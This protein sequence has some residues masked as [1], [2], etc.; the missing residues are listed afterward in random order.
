MKK[1][2]ALLLAVVMMLSLVACGGGS[3][4]DTSDPSGSSNAEKGT[5]AIYW[6]L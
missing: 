6:Y 4:P 3:E 5:W 2:L 1:F